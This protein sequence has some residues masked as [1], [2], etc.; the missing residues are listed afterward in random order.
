MQ[1]SDAK[2]Y[3]MIG[4]IFV[5]IFQGSIHAERVTKIECDPLIDDFCYVFSVSKIIFDC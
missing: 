1:S 3:R 5:F 2:D 4:T